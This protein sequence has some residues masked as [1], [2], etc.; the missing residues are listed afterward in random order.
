MKE[1]KLTDTV[2]PENLQPREKA[3]ALGIKSLRDAELMA[4]LF[5]TGIQG[6]GV[7]ALC[8]EILEDNKRHLSLLTSMRPDEVIARYK[9][10]GLAKALTLLAALELGSRAAADAIAVSNRPIMN[11]E[12]AHEFMKSKLVGLDHEE[13]W[14][15]LMRQNHTV[16]RAYNVARGGFNATAV[17]IKVI[18]SEVLMAKSPVMMLFHNHPSGALIPSAQDKALT[19][20]IVSAA[21]LLDIRVVD[22]IIISHLGFY[23]FVDNGVM[24]RP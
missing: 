1:P 15:L 6:K 19:Q 16:I 22:H 7:V 11:S 12:M 3:L 18:L 2:L 5:G 20:R 13:F 17:D 21:G 23:S 24:P 4:I 14:I 8:D 9:G 10:V